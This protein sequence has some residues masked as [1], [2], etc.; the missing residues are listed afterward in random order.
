MSRTLISLLVVVLLTCLA[1]S[2]LPGIAKTTTPTPGILWAFQFGTNIR[3]ESDTAWAVTANGDLYIVGN[4]SGSFAGQTRTRTSAYVRKYDGD[5]NELWTRSFES[6]FDHAVYG[7]AVDNSGIYVV[8]YVY[9]LIGQSMRG[10]FDAFVRKYDFSGNELWTHQFGSS[11]DDYAYAVAVDN[12]GVYIAGSAGDSI[13]WGMALGESDAFVRKYD[14][15]GNEQWTRQFGSPALDRATS[16]AVDSSGIYV[17]GNTEGALPGMNSSG[18]Q[19]AFLR[20]YD[21]DGNEQWTQQFGSPASDQATGIAANISGIYVAGNTE[22]ALPGMG[23]SGGQDA[24]LRKYDVDGNVQWTQQFGSPASDQAT[25]VA[26]T[27]SDIYVAGN[28]DGVLPGMSSSGDRDVYVRKY[29]V[30]GTLLWTQQFGSPVSDQANGITIDGSNIYVVGDTEGTIP[31]A[32]GLEGKDAFVRK[33]DLHG[34]EDWTLQ[35]GVTLSIPGDDAARGVATGDGLYATGYT[36][37]AF[38]GQT[39]LRGGNPYDAYIRKYN[40]DGAEAWTRQFA[41]GLPNEITV[42]DSAIYVVGMT[43]DAFSG[44]SDAFVG[45]Y[46]INGNEVWVRQFGT[47][48]DDSASG[49][50]ADSFGVYVAGSTRGSFPGYSNSGDSDAFVRKYDINGNDVWTLQFG[51]SGDDYVSGVAGNNSGIYVAGTTNGALPGQTSMGNVD[52]YVRKYDADGNEVWTHQFG[53]WSSDSASSITVDDAAIYVAGDAGDTLPEQ[54]P[55]MRGGVYVRKYDI[56]GNE[57]WTRQFGSS[58]DASTYGLVMD[59]SGIYMGYGRSYEGPYIRKYNA[60]GNELWSK[61]LD[62]RTWIRPSGMAIDESGVFIA[63]TTDLYNGWFGP[64]DAFVVKLTKDAFEWEE[65]YL[66]VISTR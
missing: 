44:N 55:S 1:A 6:T 20:K 27:I 50:F 36:S 64:Q 47:D 5:G 38:P 8:G 45:K 59:S 4:S 43:T 9:A 28:T 52:A 62:Y 30:N 16:I 39:S 24:F 60:D 23:S 26:A 7:V 22:G 34:N 53:T 41:V 56:S 32:T 13:D 42:A 12:S 15:D 19:D 14:L 65:L 57:L 37:G 40:V 11:S 17:A 21:T 2:S 31:G 46:D 29:D 35:F 48:D 33:Y 49:L 10:G 66:P 54:D 51:T 61:Q 3:T 25:G 58:I 18:G 63:G